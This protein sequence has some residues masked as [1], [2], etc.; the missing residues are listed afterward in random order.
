MSAA[1]D[2]VLDRELVL[3]FDLSLG[4]ALLAFLARSGDFRCGFSTRFVY[5]VR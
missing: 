1:F 4:A 2:F 5:A 3:A